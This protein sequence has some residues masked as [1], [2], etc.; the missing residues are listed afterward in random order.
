VVCCV[1]DIPYRVSSGFQDAP[2][3]VPAAL[4]ALSAAYSRL[5]LLIIDPA[6]TAWWFARRQFT[7]LSEPA[8]V[9]FDRRVTNSEGAGCLTNAE[10][11]LQHGFDDPFA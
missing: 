7:T 8:Q 3:T 9:S 6:G 4:H 1:S 11:A 5:K 10:V 2:L